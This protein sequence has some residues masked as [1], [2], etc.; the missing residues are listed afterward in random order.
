[1]RLGSDRR[2]HLILIAAGRPT[3]HGWWGSEAVARDKFVAWVG[4]YGALP[5]ARVTLVDAE[6]G[7]VLRVWPDER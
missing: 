7:A 4:V 3:M 2:Y 5:D 6:A 1:M